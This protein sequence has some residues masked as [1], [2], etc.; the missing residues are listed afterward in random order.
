MVKHVKATLDGTPA[1]AVAKMSGNLILG[2]AGVG[3]EAW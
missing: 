2:G 1:A 3:V